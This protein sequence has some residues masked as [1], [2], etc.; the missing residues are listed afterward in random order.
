[1]VWVT[2]KDCRTANSLCSL[3]F[4][5]VRDEEKFANVEAAR[6]IGGEKHIH[7]FQ[8]FSRVHLSRIVRCHTL[9]KT[10]S[11]TDYAWDCVRRFENVWDARASSPS[12]LRFAPLPLRPGRACSQMTTLHRLRLYCGNEDHHITT[13]RIILLLIFFLCLK[14]T[15]RMIFLHHLSYPVNDSSQW[16]LENQMKTASYK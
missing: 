3:R 4:C 2:T 9:T 12:S 5:F 7:H 8:C 16:K 10:A 11:Y 6:R 14:F 1:M 15:G 13:A